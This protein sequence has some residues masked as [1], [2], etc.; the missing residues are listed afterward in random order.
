MNAKDVIDSVVADNL[1]SIKYITQNL[2]DIQNRRVWAEPVI[3]VFIDGGLSVHSPSLYDGELTLLIRDVKSFKDFEPVF[4]ALEDL[5]YE[6]DRW[7]SADEGCRIFRN[8]TEGAKRLVI[9]AYPDGELCKWEK[10]G[11]KT[12]TQP[13]YEMICPE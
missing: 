9:Y 4:L 10:V 6:S 2:V 3:Q 1:S 7:I 8:K 5:G 11:E 12:V 13:I